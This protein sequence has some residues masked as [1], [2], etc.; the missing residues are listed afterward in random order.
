[1]T[2]FQSNFQDKVL[3]TI[4]QLLLIYGHKYFLMEYLFA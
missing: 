1:M 3:T 4:G 2:Y